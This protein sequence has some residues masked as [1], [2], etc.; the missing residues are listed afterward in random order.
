MIVGLSERLFSQLESSTKNERHEVK[1]M[2]TNLISRLVGIHQVECSVRH[3]LYHTSQVCYQFLMVIE[4]S[5]KFW[6]TTGELTSV[7]VLAHVV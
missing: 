6:Q 5:W 3:V 4:I 7:H 1:L 2:M